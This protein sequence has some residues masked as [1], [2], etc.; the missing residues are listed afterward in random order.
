M[1]GRLSAGLRATRFP[2]RSLFLCIWWAALLSLLAAGFVVLVTLYRMSSP[3]SLQT[4][5]ILV[6]T[7]A[8]LALALLFLRINAWVKERACRR[9]AATEVLA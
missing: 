1:S 3:A 7:G 9:L 6:W 2:V 4:M 8:A 5:E